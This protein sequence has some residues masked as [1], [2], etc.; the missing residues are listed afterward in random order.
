MALL[1]E[2]QH[3]F[4]IDL[5]YQIPR[6]EALPHLDAH[7][8]YIRDH[9]TAGVFLAS[10]PKVPLTGGVIIAMARTLDEV[11]AIAAADPLYV[12]G[13]TRFRI[14]EFNPTTTQPGLK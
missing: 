7:M 4:V 2:N 13:C 10:G 1:A 14:T 6:E 11:E 12:H 5:E 3:L 8:T 9:M